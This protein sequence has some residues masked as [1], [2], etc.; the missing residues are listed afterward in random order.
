MCARLPGSRVLVRSE[1]VRLTRAA[2]DVGVPR[3]SHSAGSLCAQ[4][5]AV[6]IENVVTASR[7]SRTATRIRVAPCILDDR[8]VLW[9]AMS[10]EEG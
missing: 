1:L 10:D 5:A 9:A 3:R 7:T 4:F 6:G 8:S 2:A